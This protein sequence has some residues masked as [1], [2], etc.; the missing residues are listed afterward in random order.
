MR[1]PVILSCA[2]TGGADTTKKSPH[3]PVTPQ[4][5]AEQALGAEAAGA[6][7]AHIHVRDPQT[8]QPAVNIEY[9]EEVVARIRA[10]KSK[11]I[12]NLTTGPGG[13]YQSRGDGACGFDPCLAINPAMSAQERVAHVLKL[14]PD[15]CSL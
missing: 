5:I 7:V 6:A 2:L 14:R 8:G 1:G 3:V 11:L 12:I 9:Y 13:L 4:A 10:A 15:I